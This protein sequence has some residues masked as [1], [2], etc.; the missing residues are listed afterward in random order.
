MFMCVCVCMCRFGDMSATNA[1]ER[2][3]YSIL[4]LYGI[5]V[6]GNLLSEL[7]GTH[8]LVLLNAETT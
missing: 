6:F 4:M 8:G 1:T 3:L 5:L 7:A 2:L